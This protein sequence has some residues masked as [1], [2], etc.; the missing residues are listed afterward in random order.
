MVRQAGTTTEETPLPK[1]CPLE[2]KELPVPAGAV[3]LKLRTPEGMVNLTRAGK[4]AAVAEN[5]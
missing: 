1:L 4:V 3:S 5:G 2:R